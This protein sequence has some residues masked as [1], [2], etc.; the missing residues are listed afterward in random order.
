MQSLEK[1]T[2]YLISDILI[3]E[4]VKHKSGS[5]LSNV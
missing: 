5:E 3:N 4:R 2:D 1:H